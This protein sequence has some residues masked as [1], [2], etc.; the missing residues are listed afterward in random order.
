MQIEGFTQSD[1][2]DLADPTPNRPGK[3]GKDSK[4]VKKKTRPNGGSLGDPST[5][6]RAPLRPGPSEEDMLWEQEMGK[7]DAAPRARRAHSRG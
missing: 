2:R 1:P 7:S 6:G 5:P 4:H 3:M